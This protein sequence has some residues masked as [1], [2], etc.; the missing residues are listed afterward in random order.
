MAPR[1][2]PPGIY[3]SSTIGV[4]YR[5]SEPAEFRWLCSFC[6]KEIRNGVFRNNH[7]YCNLRHA[8]LGALKGVFS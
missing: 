1:V 3:T 8:L 6:E 5:T 7:V 4:P 2:D